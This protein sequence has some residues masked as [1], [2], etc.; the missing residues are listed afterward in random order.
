MNAWSN[1]ILLSAVD[2][3]A[4]RGR[5]RAGAQS[6][7][8]KKLYRWVDKNG[9]VHY[10]D[11]V[12]AEY[13]EQDR[14]VL[15]RQGVPVGREEGTIT[16]EEAA[17]K[18]AADK[19][20]RDEQKRKLRDRVLLQTYQSVQELEILRDNRL[21]LVDAQLTIQEQSLSNLRAQRAQIERMASRYAPANTGADAQP[22]PDELAADLDALGQRHRDAG[23]Q[24]GAA[25]RGAREHPPDLRGR[26]RALQGTARDQAALSPAQPVLPKPP[27][28]RALASNSSTTSNSTCTTG[29]T[30]I[31]AM[32]SPGAIVNARVAAVPHR[33]HHLPL[34]V[35]VDQ[36]DEVAEHDAVLVPESRARQQHGREPRVAE[37]DRDA[38]RHELVS[39]G[40]SI[41]R[42]VDA[43]AKVE[44]RGAGGRAP[45][46]LHVAADARVEDADFEFPHGPIIPELERFATPKLRAYGRSRLTM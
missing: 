19:A 3:R 39:P 17:V 33:H 30:T 11:S 36:P 1:K 10:G 24:P 31:C 21:D 15:N 44:A 42:R 9:Q 23:R 27:A 18:A 2:A 13:A 6:D 41:E 12:P 14:D 32:R 35:R 5:R 25:A 43:G 46:Q 38:G 26:H 37:V 45:R 29:T 16:P 22:L 7:K 20:A 34:V 28:P 4:A 40:S 8:Q